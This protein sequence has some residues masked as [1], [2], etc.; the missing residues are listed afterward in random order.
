MEDVIKEKTVD[1]PVGVARYAELIWAAFT[2]LLIQM[3]KPF[4]LG[5]V[6]PGYWVGS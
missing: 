5:R 3:A 6:I 1:S 4:W 2:E